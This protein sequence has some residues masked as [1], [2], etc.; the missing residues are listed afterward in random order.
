MPTATLCILCRK[1]IEPDA[2]GRPR[3]FHPDCRRRW[4]SKHMEGNGRRKGRHKLTPYTPYPLDPI[5]TEAYAG[6]DAAQIRRVGVAYWGKLAEFSYWAYDLLNPL[7]F[8]GRVAHPL[9]Q[10]C[11]VM[12]YGR[13][14]GKS[15]TGDLDRPVIDVFLSLWTGKQYQH[16]HYAWVFGIIAHEMMHFDSELRWRQ[17]RAG[18]YNTSHENE[19]WQA[20]IAQASPLLGVDLSRGK[21]PHECWPHE[22]WTP[23]QWQ[24]LEKSLAKRKLEF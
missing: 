14:I 11:Q 7:C 13:C 2:Y 20:G 18:H 1:P 6:L 3:Q 16:V 19:F 5:K 12:P 15:H 10:F 24:R 21:F 17:Q 23:R 8:A 22:C 4:R 9:F